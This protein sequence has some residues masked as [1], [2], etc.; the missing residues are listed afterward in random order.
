MGT[1]TH[2]LLA[3][4]YTQPQQ[5]AEEQV[6][7]KTVKPLAEERS[8]LAKADK[9]GTY[10]GDAAL[11]DEAWNLSKVMANYFWKAH[12]LDRDKLTVMYVETTLVAPLLN[13]Y[14]VAII[15]LVLADEE[16]KVAWVSDP[17]PWWGG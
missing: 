11:I 2:A 6:H 8:Q 13:G 1:F 5:D 4:G 10:D 3:H 16:R 7:E 14:P 12:P 9:L 15:D 17:P